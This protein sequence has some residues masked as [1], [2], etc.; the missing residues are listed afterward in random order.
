MD[1]PTILI[2]DD[3]MYQLYVLGNLAKQ[4]GYEVLQARSGKN[5]LELVRTHAPDLILLDLNM[6]D[7]NGIEV[8]ETL[9]G[10]AF[11]GRIFVISADIQETTRAQCLSLGAADILHKPVKEE[12]LRNKLQEAFA[13]LAMK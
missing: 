4:V 11:K 2:A 6:P 8:L 7:G 9:K 3:S 5:C 12:V 13:T 1:M 10:E